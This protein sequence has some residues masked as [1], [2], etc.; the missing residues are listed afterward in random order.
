MYPY[1]HSS[2]DPFSALL[3]FFFLLSKVHY[4]GNVSYLMVTIY[5]RKN[6]SLIYK[7]RTKK[8][9]EREREREARENIKHYTYQTAETSSYDNGDLPCPDNGPFKTRSIVVT[10]PFC[11]LF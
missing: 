8:K 11:E 1:R 2:S 6:Y 7:N 3:S 5:H 9:R 4:Q 10:K